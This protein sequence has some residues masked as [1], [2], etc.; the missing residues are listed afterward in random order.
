MEGSRSLKRRHLVYYLEVFDGFTKVNSHV[1]VPV[2]PLPVINLVPTG[3]PESGQDSI[4]V[5]V[6][7]TVILDAGNAD[8]PPE[9]QYMWSNGFS[10]RHLIAR[11]NGNWI[12][13]PPIPEAVRYIIDGGG[14]IPYL[15]KKF[16]GTGS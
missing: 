5:C 1:I 12:D 2:H 15:Q 4:T 3:I 6:R 16:S 14:L 13:F 9:M 8:N 10:G 11:T 7:D